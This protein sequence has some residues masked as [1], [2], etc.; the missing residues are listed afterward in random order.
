MTRRAAIDAPDLDAAA[1]GAPLP[2]PVRHYLADVLRLRPGDAVELADGTG[3][4]ARGRLE[5]AGRRWRLTAVEWVPPPPPG[6]PLTLLAG[7]LKPKR[8]ALLVEKAVELGVTQLVPVL[9]RH[10]GSLP[11]DSQHRALL[12]RWQRLALEAS[13]QCRRTA[14]PR[15]SPPQA[16]SDALADRSEPNRLVADPTA[17][18]T[19]PAGPAWIAG[20]PTALLVGPEGGLHP[21]ELAAARAAGFVPISLGA[22]P[23]RAETAA[24]ALVAVARDRL[25]LAA[26]EL[27]TLGKASCP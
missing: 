24:V 3:R 9:T 18:E 19:W 14:V 16:L 7:L 8:W 15:V 4:L 6:P 20:A 1:A 5:Q 2:A 21:D 23:L 26:A 12:E 22:Y 10:V 25:G 27:A 13:Q 11:P 17:G